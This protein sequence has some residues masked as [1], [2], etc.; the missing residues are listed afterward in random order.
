MTGNLLFDVVMIVLNLYAI[1]HILYDV[2]ECILN[3]YATYK[4]NACMVLV[5][6][7][8]EE[9]L[10]YDVRMA[11]KKSENLNLPLFILNE[12]LNEDETKMLIRLTSGSCQTKLVQK[13]DF[14][15]ALKGENAISAYI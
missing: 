13:D 14:F 7:N 4:P 5:A 10:E 9:S 6:K 8:G 1:M 15:D 12:S 2:S 11:M 3:R